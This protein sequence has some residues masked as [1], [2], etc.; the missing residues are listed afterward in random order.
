MTDNLDLAAIEAAVTERCKSANLRGYSDEY[1]PNY[2]IMALIAEVK[3]L[4]GLL[5]QVYDEKEIVYHAYGR[6]TAENERLREDVLQHKAFITGCESIISKFR[7]VV[8]EINNTAVEFQE[9]GPF[10]QQ[11]AFERVTEIYKLSLLPVPPDDADRIGED[12][13]SME[14]A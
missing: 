6:L 9:L 8:N 7:V 12:N 13:K 10:E 5:N 4:T 2:Q 14:D 11:E 3:R 1:H